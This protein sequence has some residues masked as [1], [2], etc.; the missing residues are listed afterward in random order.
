MLF[1]PLNLSVLI[2]T[3][4][5]LL[6]N[7]DGVKSFAST[8]G[9]AELYL[10]TPTPTQVYPA[11]WFQSLTHHVAHAADRAALPKCD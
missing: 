10:R 1:K 3:K 4:A 6:D 5:D 9:A 11:F 2:S 7:G 8:V